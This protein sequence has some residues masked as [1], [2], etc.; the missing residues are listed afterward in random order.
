MQT[1]MQ[2][3][4]A[5]VAHLGLAVLMIGLVLTGPAEAAYWGASAVTAVPEFLVSGEVTSYTVRSTP[6]GNGV[7]TN[8]VPECGNTARVSCVGISRLFIPVT[9]PFET[10]F[11]TIW[12]RAADNMSTGYVRASLYRQPITNNQ[13]TPT[14]IG[15][16]MT[17]T[18]AG[19]GYQIVTAPIVVGRFGTLIEKI[20]RGFTY[21]FVIELAEGWELSR[22]GGPSPN[23]IAFDVGFDLDTCD[24]EHPDF[25]PSCLNI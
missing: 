4:A 19:M 22:P 11:R 16:V 23:V 9:A 14:L 15:S 12:L 25:D 7:M 21:Y 20:R 1:I 10:E 8:A 24:L 18:R 2:P 13:A 5:S 3:L 6:Y 17:Q